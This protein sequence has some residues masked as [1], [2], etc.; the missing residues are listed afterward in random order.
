[1]ATGRSAAALWRTA[2][3]LRPARVRG[4]PLPRLLFLTDPARTP[5]PQAAIERLPRGAAVIYRAFGARD[6]LAIGRKLARAARRGGVLFLVGADAALAARLGA[7]GIHLPERSARAAAG[8]K[9]TRPTWLVTCAAHSA[10]A[11]VRAGRAGADAVVVSPVFES[12]SPSAGRPLGALRFRQLTRAARTP[13]YALGGVNA[14][15]ARQLIGSEAAGIAAVDA[16][17]AAA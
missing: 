10:A 2:R 1:M 7:D 9:R 14:Q 16:L 11:V 15:T 17:A 6:A 4:K 8:I 5:E 12:R 13:V 3:T